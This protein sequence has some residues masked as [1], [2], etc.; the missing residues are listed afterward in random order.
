[1]IEAICAKPMRWLAAAHSRLRHVSECAVP[2]IYKLVALLLCGPIF[3]THNFLFKI[4]YAAGVRR[5]LLLSA[6]QGFLSIEH[7]ALQA[8]LN[9]IDLHLRKGGLQSLR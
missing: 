1:M 5:L 8:D 2:D 6:D 4:C 7:Q 9:L 3:Q